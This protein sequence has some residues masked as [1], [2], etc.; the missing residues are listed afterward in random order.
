[1]GNDAE[2]FR[3]RKPWEGGSRW[4]WIAVGIIL[5]VIA[6][7]VL[8]NVFGGEEPQPVTWPEWIRAHDGEV[9][10]LRFSEVPARFAEAWGDRC[11]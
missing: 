10:E 7:F 8:G 5:V 2:K 9:C 4:E 3:Y 6:A 11:L 1:M